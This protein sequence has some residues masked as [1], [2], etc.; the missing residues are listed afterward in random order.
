MDDVHLQVVVLAVDGMLAGRM[1]MEL[2]GRELL[3]A[4][5]EESIGELRLEPVALLLTFVQVNL[6]SA[7]SPVNQN[8]LRKVSVRHLKVVFF[9]GHR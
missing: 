9:L 8:I 5:V 6:D 3:A 4:C 2:L 1:E 7:A